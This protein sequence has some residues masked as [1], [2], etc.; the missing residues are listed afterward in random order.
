M[1]FNPERKPGP[2]LVP[3]RKEREE[4]TGK[5]T[6]PLKESIFQAWYKHYAKQ[7][8]ISPNP[9]EV[10]HHYDYR[11]AFELGEGPNE[12]GHWPSKHKKATHPNRFIRTQTPRGVEV[13]DTAT[14]KRYIED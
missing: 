8:G 4:K 7:T 6:H 2:P 12:E 3:E 1:E 9:D 13:Y 5:F 14:E 10:H 11:S